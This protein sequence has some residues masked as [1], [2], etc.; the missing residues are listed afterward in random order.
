MPV[1]RAFLVAALIVDAIGRI[2]ERKDRK[3]YYKEKSEYYKEKREKED[4]D[5]NRIERKAD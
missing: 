1:L 3:K 2:L 4:N 5:A